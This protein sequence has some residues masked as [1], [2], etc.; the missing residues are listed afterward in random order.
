[1]QSQTCPW[2]LQVSLFS[3][4]NWDNNADFYGHF[5]HFL[6]VSVTCHLEEAFSGHPR[7]EVPVLFALCFSFLL[8]YCSI[9]FFMCIMFIFHYLS[10]PLECNLIKGQD[11]CLLCTWNCLTQTGIV[12]SRT[13]YREKEKSQHLLALAA[14][15]WPGSD[16]WALALCRTWRR[17]RHT[18]L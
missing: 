9:Y 10:S 6:Q 14:R 5:L 3:C 12:N 7:L 1:M 13:N 8:T 16:R 4:L 11:L 17:S 15:G 18:G 2:P